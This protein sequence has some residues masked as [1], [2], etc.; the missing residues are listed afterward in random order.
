MIINGREIATAL[1]LKT[2]SQI[3][4]LSFQPLLIDVLIGSD[5]A[6]LS[7]VRIKQR[8]AEECGIAFEVLQ[9]P[10]SCSTEEVILAI[11]QLLLK[12]SLCGLLIQLPLPANFDE[13]KILQAI[14][15][16]LDVDILNDK[17]R[18]NFYSGLGKMEP[19]TAGA[20]LHILDSLNEPWQD[21]QFL[22]LGQGELVGRPTTY[23]L[24]QRGYKVWTADSSTVNIA[25]LLASADCIISGVGKPD[26]IF[27][28]DLKPGCI[29]IDAGTS[30]A[31]GSITGDV[32]FGSVQEIAKYITP[33]PGGVG[34]VTVAK[35]LQNVLSVAA[36]KI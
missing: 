28:K 15:V 34:P 30:E 27:A 18:E 8:K 20:I 5:P 17:S 3:E 31:S 2:K 23:L 4:S 14:P 22:V 32:N 35:L 26:L 11:E 33:V 10:E 12:P 7:Y 19:P 24:Q 9:L 21:L 29:V 6:S 1:N 13:Q 25:E 16:E 36:N